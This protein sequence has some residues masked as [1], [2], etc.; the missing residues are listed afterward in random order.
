[1]RQTPPQIAGI[2]A[3]SARQFWHSKGGNF[4]MM[5]ATML[6]VLLGAVGLAVDFAS[7]SKAHS[8]LQDALDA[9]VL[10]AS[11][12]NDKTLSR[13]DVFEDYLAANLADELSIKIVDS[14]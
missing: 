10:A 8:S 4:S 5:F 3:M 9:A 14:E 2:T 6:P 7:L 1:M 13:Q 11:R 12:I